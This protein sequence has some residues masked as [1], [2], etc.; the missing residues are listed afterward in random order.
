MTKLLQA[1][2]VVQV[3]H[4]SPL[5]SSSVISAL[6]LSAA[7]RYRSRVGCFWSMLILLLPRPLPQPRMCLLATSR[8]GR[9]AAFALRAQR[10]RVRC[11][12]ATADTCSERTGSHVPHVPVTP[13]S[14]GCPR[15][16]PLRAPGYPM[17]PGS[18]YDMKAA[19]PAAPTRGRMQRAPRRAARRV[20]PVAPRHPGR[21]DVPNEARDT[22]CAPPRARRPFSIAAWRYKKYDDLLYKHD[23]ISS[24]RCQI[25]AVV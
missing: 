20:G 12:T 6:L 17:D 19:S 2:R 13:C 10:R 3:I 7:I 16:V 15:H 5:L 22:T 9:A 23:D 25:K 4:F 8:P 11:I 21:R 14:P 18:W 1:Y 24:S